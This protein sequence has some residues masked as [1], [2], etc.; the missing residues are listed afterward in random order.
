MGDKK[1]DMVFTD[2]PYGINYHGMQNS[3]QWNFIE[4]DDLEEEQFN[5]FLLKVASNF[6]DFS[7]NEAAYYICHYDKYNYLFRKSFEKYGYQW[8]ATIIWVK[9]SP[10]FSFAQYKYKHEPILYLVKS[11]NTVLWYGDMKNNTVWK[12]DWDKEKVYKWF[13]S[14]LEKEKKYGKTTIW[15]DK[16]ERGDHPT[17]KPVSLI[18]KALFNSSK[19]DNIVL[20][21]FLGSGSTL[22]ACEKT[23]RICYGMEIEPKYVDVI[24]KRWEDYTGQKAVKL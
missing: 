18:I 16:K 11:G 17:I 5:E 6:N 23:N 10:A 21:L 3:K 8:R 14:L 22:I 9:N 15:E 20:D 2:P 4:N 19:Q 12:E 7:K 24:I 13:Q 1:A